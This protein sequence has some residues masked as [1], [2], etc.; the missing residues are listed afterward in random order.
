ML[1]LAAEAV[2]SNDSGTYKAHFL[3]FWSSFLAREMSQEY[4]SAQTTPV[5]RN[6]LSAILLRGGDDEPFA[7]TFLYSEMSSDSFDA[8]YDADDYSRH[9][10]DSPCPVVASSQV[11]YEGGCFVSSENVGPDTIFTGFVENYGDSDDDD[12]DDDDDDGHSSM[13]SNSSV[14]RSRVLADGS[15]AT[16]S[17]REASSKSSTAEVYIEGGFKLQQAVPRLFGLRLNVSHR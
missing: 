6:F 8:A 2:A 3:S 4:Q 1:L 13:L 9:T 15:Y 7:S 11:L 10:Q 17:R 16:H 5:S 14:R 12:D